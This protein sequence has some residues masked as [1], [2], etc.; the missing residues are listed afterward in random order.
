[1]LCNRDDL[2]A[3]EWMSN[4]CGT[5]PPPQFRGIDIYPG[6]DP[7]RDYHAMEQRNKQ[8]VLIMNTDAY[9]Y[10]NIYTSLNIM[11]MLLK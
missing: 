7:G 10:V 4:L 6:N 2:Y 5:T 8:V 3:C 1:M 11:I 9:L